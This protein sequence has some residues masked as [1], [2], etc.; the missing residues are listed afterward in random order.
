[1]TAL[2]IDKRTHIHG[3][4]G[5]YSINFRDVQF[6]NHNDISL[7]KGGLN[8]GVVTT[9]VF[10]VAIGSQELQ[11]VLIGLCIDKGIDRNKEP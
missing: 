4:R 10:F 1:V 6:V 3:V 2:C 11:K 9:E 8:G 7:Q 5:T